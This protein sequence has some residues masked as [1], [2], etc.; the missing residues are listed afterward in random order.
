MISFHIDETIAMMGCQKDILTY[1]KNEKSDNEPCNLIFMGIK[2]NVSENRSPP[3]NGQCR[4]YFVDQALESV[5]LI[6]R[7]YHRAIFNIFFSKIPAIFIEI[8]PS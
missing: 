3:F 6:K 7:S 4:H 2:K 8:I 5:W 1:M